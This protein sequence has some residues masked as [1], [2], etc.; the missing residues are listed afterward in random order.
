MQTVDPKTG[1]SVSGFG[2]IN[3]GSFLLGKS[4]REGMSMLRVQF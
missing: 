1:S 2:H 4:P 3:T